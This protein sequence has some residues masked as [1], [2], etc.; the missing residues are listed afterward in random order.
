[1]N[2]NVVMLGSCRLTLK[3]AND[4]KDELTYTHSTKD[5]IQLI[6]FLREGKTYPEPY[7]KLCYRNPLTIHSKGT[8]THNNK[9]KDLLD[10]ANVVFI[11]ICSRKLY[12]HNGYYLYSLYLTHKRHKKLVPKT[13][14]DTI[15]FIEQ[16]DEE[17]EQDILKI[18][19]LLSNK[20]I[21]LVTHCQYNDEEGKTLAK[22][23]ELIELLNAI[24]LRHN[25]PVINPINTFKDCAKQSRYLK[26]STHYKPYGNR[27]IRD[28][29]RKYL[30]KVLT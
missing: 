8:I 4:I 26:N 17:I 6:E 12:R 14:K 1:M 29:Y 24:G 15:E 11:E 27:K 19:E 21:I 16:T 7:N 20:K 2:N 23:D 3:N 9:Y 10:N 22:R 18:I 5:V 25:I 13:I 30:Q 28:T